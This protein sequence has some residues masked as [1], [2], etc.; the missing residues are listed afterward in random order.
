MTI[1]HVLK[2]FCFCIDGN[3][4]LA[5]PT[6]STADVVM[7]ELH[8]SE[9]QPRNFIGVKCFPAVQMILIKQ[10]TLHFV[11]LSCLLILPVIQLKMFQ[12]LDFKMKWVY[13]T[14][15]GLYKS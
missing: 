14:L 15:T 10:N 12:I 2:T 8:N 9:L 5:T 7:V 1:N 4:L 11:L 3:G 13:C 6:A